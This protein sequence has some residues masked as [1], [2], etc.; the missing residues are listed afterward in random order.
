[1][2]EWA[3]SQDESGNQPLQPFHL[4]HLISNSVVVFLGPGG[5]SHMRVI[6][7]CFVLNVF[8]FFLELF[9]ILIVEILGD[10]YPKFPIW[11]GEEGGGG[12]W[13][14]WKDSDGTV[15]VSSRD[16]QLR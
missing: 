14:V 2:G 8:G 15:I 4:E 10:S 11:M 12:W 3:G 13:E 7:V 5:R 16:Q 6:R 9:W 1:M